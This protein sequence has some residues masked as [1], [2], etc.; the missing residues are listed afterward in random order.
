MLI[1]RMGNRMKKKS[2]I[3]AR[4]RSRRSRRAISSVI[5]HV[6]GFFI[7][8]STHW[9]SHGDAFVCRVTEFATSEF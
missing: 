6:I 4:Q 5:S 2:S 9:S 7:L 8:H 1:N 3:L